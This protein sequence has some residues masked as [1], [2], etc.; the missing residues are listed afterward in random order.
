MKILIYGINF[1]PEPTGIGRYSGDMAAWLAANG[2]EVRAIAAP[3]YYPDWKVGAGHSAAAYRREIWNGL[4][5]WR[6]PLWVPNQPSGTKRVLHLVSFA[7][8]SLPVLARHVVWGPDVV[9]TVAPAFACAPPGW[10][11][12]RLCGAL[13]WLHV[14]DFEVDAAYRLGMLGG[15]RRQK[16]IRALE[17]WAFQ[18]F[19]KVSS[20]SHRMVD[21]LALKGVP[22]DKTVHFPNWVDVDSIRPMPAP[23]NYRAALGIAPDAVVA[24]YS[25]TMAGKQGLDLLPLAARLLQGVPNLVFVI[26]GDGLMKPVIEAQCADLP[27]VKLL[28]LQPAE[29]L[30]D[31]LNLADIHLLPQSP[32]VAD[33]VMPSKL[34]G[35]LASGR[36]VVATSH[37]GTELAHVVGPCGLVVPP[38]DA[39]DFAAAVQQL[40]LDAPLRTRLGQ[41]ARRYAEQNLGRDAVL[42]RFV[43]HLTGSSPGAAAAPVT[44]QDAPP[45]P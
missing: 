11:T 30:P 45:Q 41:A 25:G 7:V 12:A 44:V 35:M 18:R 29:K 36:P 39:A 31:L 14:Q 13:A 16:I 33:L 17:R 34:G 9:I 4:R 27:N 15:T 6:T 42:Q 43:N 40:A 32:D 37:P 5:V 26:C 38:L 3:P 10:L 8:A 2:H 20:I 21:R 24:L 28:P 23:S 19:D 1:A 22:A